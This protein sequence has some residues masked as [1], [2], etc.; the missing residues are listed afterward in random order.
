MVQLKT[1]S[2]KVPVRGEF[3]VIVGGSGSAG[4]CAALRKMDAFVER[5]E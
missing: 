2:Q 5:S 3:D 4:V 1:P